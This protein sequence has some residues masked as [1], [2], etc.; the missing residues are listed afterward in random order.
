MK[1]GL[2]DIKG[3]EVSKGDLFIYEGEIYEVEYHY[4][5]FGF[6]DNNE[7]FNPF[8]EVFLNNKLNIEII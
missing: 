5:A 4:G 6:H 2:V 1:T 8:V 3:I 7:S